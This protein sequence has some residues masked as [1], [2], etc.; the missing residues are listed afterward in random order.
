MIS[1]IKKPETRIVTGFQDLCK[2]A[3]DGIRIWLRQKYIERTMVL[4]P[5]RPQS[6]AR[7]D[8]FSCHY[9]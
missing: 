2:Q 7:S 6:N 9:L 8:R 4:S 1:R 3:R 5:S